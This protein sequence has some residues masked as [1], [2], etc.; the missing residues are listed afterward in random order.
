[1]RALQ[2]E[3]E[4]LTNRAA[5]AIAGDHPIGAHGTRTLGRFDVDLGKV[6]GLAHSRHAAAPAHVRQL[7]HRLGGLMRKPFH[8]VLLDVEHG[9]IALRRLTGHLEV[10]H[11]GAFPI[12]APAR[13][14]QSG[15][16]QGLVR[17]DPGQDLLRPARHADGPAPRAVAL[18]GFD[19]QAAN[20]MAGQQR[21]KRQAHRP[22][23]SDEDRHAQRQ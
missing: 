23:A 13:P 21:R 10:Q 7:R 9:R 3:P 4:L 2:L 12:T 6:I 20:A 17:A 22:A 11:L 5:A 1:L 18:V 16:D 14:R 8:V 19:N 15:R